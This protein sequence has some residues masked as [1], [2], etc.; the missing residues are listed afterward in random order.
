MFFKNYVVL[1]TFYASQGNLRK[2]SERHLYFEDAIDVY[3][4]E[5]FS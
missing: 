3:V 4:R 1:E 2:L 5:L